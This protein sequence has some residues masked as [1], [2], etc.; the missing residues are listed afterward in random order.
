MKRTAINSVR[1]SSLRGL[2]LLHADLQRSEDG[3]VSLLSRIKVNRWFARL[4]KI[5]LKIRLLA[6]SQQRLC[7]HRLKS[8]IKDRLEECGWVD[9]VR[10]I[11][12]G[13]FRMSAFT[14]IPRSLQDFNSTVLLDLESLLVQHAGLN[15][16][17]DAESIYEGDQKVKTADKL[18]KEISPKAKAKVPDIL[19]AELLRQCHSIICG[20]I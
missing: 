10:A 16:C 13:I 7:T 3:Q 14:N 2:H 18:H 12:A 4:H 9:D 19:K 17:V 11:A 8:I 15:H 6:D 5:L 20:S 1:N